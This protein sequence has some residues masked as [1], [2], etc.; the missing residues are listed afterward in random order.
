MDVSEYDYEFDDDLIAQ[1]PAE[2]RDHSRLMFVG[3][4]KIEH[5]KFYNITDILKEGDVLVK[6]RSKVI[7]ARLLGKKD[8][9][10]KVELLLYNECKTDIWDCLIKGSNIREGVKISVGNHDLEVIEHLHGGRFLVRCSNGGRVMREHGEMPTP[11]Y[12]D[13]SLSD[14]DQYQT[15]Y[16]EES[17]SIAAP[18]AGFHFTE[19]I[20]EELENKGVEIHDVILHVGP[21]TFIPIRTDEVEEHHMDEEYYVVP[22]GTARAVTRANEEGRRVILVGTTTVRAIESV[23]QDGVVKPGEGWTDLY[24][25]PGYEFRSGIDLFLTNFH[26]PRSTPLMLV[27][28]FGGEKRLREAYEQAVKRRYR[29]YSFG[30]AMLLEGKG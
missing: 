24:I 27:H 6:N 28:A 7:P 17:G 5:L 22:K 2:P 11:P 9:G 13:R 1:E 16:A 21:G 18:T 23:S 10:G 25:Y 12:I 30:D 19:D 14:P 15:V 29:F 26:L 3:K 8:T 20:L 4:E